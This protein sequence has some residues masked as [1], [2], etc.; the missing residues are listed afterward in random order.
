MQVVLRQA[1][2]D[3]AR[4]ASTGLVLLAGGWGSRAPQPAPISVTCPASPNCICEYGG[5]Y[6]EHHSPCAS[7]SWDTLCLAVVFGFIGGIIT[8]F[9]IVWGLRHP[10]LEGSSPALRYPRGKLLRSVT[11]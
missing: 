7:T 5:R 4:G 10:V 1:L 3:L 11:E 9:G 6:Q 8:A 2:G